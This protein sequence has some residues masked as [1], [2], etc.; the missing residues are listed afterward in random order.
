[1]IATDSVVATCAHPVAAVDVSVPPSD[2]VGDGGR[3]VLGRIA[4]IMDAFDQG[5]QVLTLCDL[6]RHVNLPK[7]TVHRLVEQLRGLGWL[8]RDH[9][10]GYRIGMRLFELG[11]LALQRNQL[12]DAAFPHLYALATKTGLAVQLGVLDRGEVVYLERFVVG[13]FSLPTRLGGR[14]P[15]HCT[16]LGKAM[17]AFDDLA[18]D[19]V[20]GAALARRTDPRSRNQTRSEQSSIGFVRRASPTTSRSPTKG[21]DACRRRSATRVERSGRSR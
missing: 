16:A 10:N 20:M 3:T 17:L 12:R 18:A 1:M 19:E 11:G 13:G 5:E 15:A 9:R 6:S 7:S 2:E 14:M 21:W 4:T 8:E